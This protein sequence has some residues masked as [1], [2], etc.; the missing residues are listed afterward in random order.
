[1]KT[2][3]ELVAEINA[4]KIC[5]PHSVEDTIDM[6]GVTEVATLD[7]DEHRWYIMATKVFKVG[8][9]FFGVYGPVS[10]KSESMGYSD[11]GHECEAFEME[12]VPSVT[13][14]VKK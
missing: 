5:T 12:Q 7:E 1:M 10:L 14:K 9:E 2:A 4:A 3:K 6:E 8:D 13:Y 11:V